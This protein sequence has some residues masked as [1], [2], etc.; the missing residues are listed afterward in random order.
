MYT[1]TVV[2]EVD[3]GTDALKSGKA[4]VDLAIMKAANKTAG[5]LN[6][7]A[8]RDFKEHIETPFPDVKARR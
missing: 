6:H 2:D 1:I 5:M 7:I 4:G 3:Y 8:G